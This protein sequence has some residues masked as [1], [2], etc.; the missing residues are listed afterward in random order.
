ME[1]NPDVVLCYPWSVVIDGEGAVQET[2]RRDRPGSL[3]GWRLFIDISRDLNQCEET[4]GLMRSETL[5]ATGLQRNYTDSDRTLLAH[6]ALLGT[7]REVPEE[8]F[9]KRIHEGNSTSALPDWRSRMQWFGSQYVTGIRLPHW[10]QLWHYLALVSRTPIP[11]RQKARCWASM[12]G[13]ITSNRK[14]RSLGKDLVLA[15]A[16]IMQ[17]VARKALRRGAAEP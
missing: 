1:A 14:W 6:M 13:W 10:Q 12:P 17:L 5:R 9:F 2:V 7:Y 11:V 3:Q 16:A 15:A 4:Y 8:L